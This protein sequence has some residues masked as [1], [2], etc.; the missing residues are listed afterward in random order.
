MRTPSAQ[1]R[2]RRATS[3]SSLTRGPSRRCNQLS[4]QMALLPLHCST[5]SIF[6]RERQKSFTL[7]FRSI[8]GTGVRRLICATARISMSVSLTPQRGSSG[9]RSSTCFR[10]NFPR[11][12]SPSSIPLKRT[13]VMSSSIAT[14]Q[15]FNPVR[16]V[17]NDH[18]FATAHSHR[19]RC[20][21]SAFAT[22]CGSSL[23]G[24]H[25]IS[26]RVAR[27]PALLTAAVQTQQ[28]S[29]TVMA[30]SSMPSKST[31]TSR[32]TR[33]GCGESSVML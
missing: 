17:M 1:H 28:T 9:N 7:L 18:G 14:T 33:H 30:N 12:H 2:L 22:K 11:R 20:C 21:S 31:S 5:I 19:R 27:C 26:L 32:K 15:A 16:A 23:I 6:I 24:M 10:F 3:S 4:M 8:S 13:S 29:M 25:G